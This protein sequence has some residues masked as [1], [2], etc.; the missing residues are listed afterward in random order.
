M[1]ASFASS[2]TSLPAKMATVVAR[3][4]ACLP[5]TTTAHHPMTR[6]REAAVMVAPSAAM[7]QKMATARAA[8]AEMQP[9]KPSRRRACG[10]LRRHE[11]HKQHIC[12]CGEQKSHRHQVP[13]CSLGKNKHPV[14]LCL[15]SPSHATRHHLGLCQSADKCRHPVAVHRLPHCGRRDWFHRVKKTCVPSPPAKK[16]SKT[17]KNMYINRENV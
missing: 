10:A 11:H 16:Q 13:C 3:S 12:L 1:G 4:H 2:R 15:Y 6:T 7:V 17:H 8:A 14:H 5:T 9:Q